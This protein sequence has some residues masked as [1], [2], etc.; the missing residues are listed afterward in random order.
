VDTTRT[1]R[2]VEHEA[3]AAAESIADFAL[4]SVGDT[5]FLAHVTDVDPN[6]PVEPTNGRAP[7]GRKDPVRARL[8]LE[9][10]GDSLAMGAPAAAP[11]EPTNGR[12]P[13][14]RKDPVRARL[15]LE[16]LGDSLA[17]GAPAAAS[18]ISIRAHSF[19]GVALAP[20]DAKSGE[21]LVAWAGVDEGQPQ[22]FLT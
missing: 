10:L 3:I 5:R 7:D 21:L 2:V 18:P 17:M 11:V 8:S 6:A 14:G 9:M 16:M 22:V 15:S 13:D 12:A 1:P 4:A 19:G 20:G